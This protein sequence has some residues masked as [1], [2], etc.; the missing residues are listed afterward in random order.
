M[1]KQEKAV[2]ELIADEEEST[3]KINITHTKN[4]E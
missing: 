3:L 2:I 1:K 4:I